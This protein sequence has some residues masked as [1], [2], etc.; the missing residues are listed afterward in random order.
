MAQYCSKGL[1]QGVEGEVGM[2]RAAWGDGSL[3]GCLLQN[4]TWEEA[5]SKLQ[6]L[7][8]EGR[9]GGRTEEDVAD[10]ACR[11]SLRGWVE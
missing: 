9:S 10:E 4:L 7:S 2:T 6:V 8:T 3:A 1:T 5:G 11:T